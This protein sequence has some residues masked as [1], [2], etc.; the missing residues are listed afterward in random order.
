MNYYLGDN[1]M[2]QPCLSSEEIPQQSNDLQQ[3]M[4]PIQKLSCASFALDVKPSD[5]LLEESTKRPSMSSGI[6]GDY[7]TI[8]DP[9]LWPPIDSS[10]PLGQPFLNSW[11]GLMPDLTDTPKAEIVFP[12]MG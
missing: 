9:L 12:G 1:T 7:P 11:T 3:P 2:P 8:I 5:T 6:E 4:D 10:D